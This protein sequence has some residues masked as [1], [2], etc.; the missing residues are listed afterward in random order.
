MPRIRKLSVLFV[1]N[2]F[3]SRNDV[4]ALVGNLATAAGLDFR[5]S[6]ISAGGASLRR[7]WNG[8][9]ARPAI[10]QGGYD[11]VV[12]Q[13][14]STLPVKNAQRMHE[15]VRL[16]DNAI[17]A[18]GART[19]LFM[20]WA[21]RHEPQNQRK[22]ARAYT[23]I[24]DELGAT[25]LPAGL[26]WEVCL[27]FGHAPVLYDRDGSHPTLAGSHLAACVIYLVLFDRKIVPGVSLPGV[28]VQEMKK[29]A[30]AATRVIRSE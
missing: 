23:E 27:R 12:L 28:A 2:S 26:A 20:T 1:G 17:R 5:H 19:A 9:E 24:A 7:H 8:A 30:D 4:P 10:E 18:A 13:E 29:I 3:T 6:L 21:R 14:Q 15:N 16:F 22:I 11:Y 25:L